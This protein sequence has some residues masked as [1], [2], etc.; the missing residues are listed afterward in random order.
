MRQIVNIAHVTLSAKI[1][2]EALGTFPTDA[3]NAVPL[4]TV[5]D[6]I[7][8]LD[9]GGGVVEHQKIVMTLIAYSVIAARAVIP[10]YYNGLVRSF[11]G[12]IGSAGSVGKRRRRFAD[13]YDSAGVTF[14]AILIVPFPVV[15]SNYPQAYF[16][17]FQPTAI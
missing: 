3:D 6:D 14:A 17:H 12:R 15:A 10:L 16:E 5:A 8:V 1:I 2:V 9:S 11:V 13:F 7:V 4:T